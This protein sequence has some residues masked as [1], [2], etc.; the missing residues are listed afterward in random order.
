MAD[1]EIEL[2]KTSQL[3]RERSPSLPGIN[4]LNPESQRSSDP[5]LERN[6]DLEKDVPQDGADDGDPIYHYLTFQT[7]LPS[8]TT[9]YPT[10]AGQEQPPS[11]PDLV[12]FTSPFEWSDSRKN[13]IIWISCLITSL[14]AFTAG[15]YSP[16][17]GQ[18]TAEW[19]VSN[20][21]ALVGITT[22]TSGM[23][24]SLPRCTEWSNMT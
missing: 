19:H 18:M 17:I 24:H 9:I 13:Y 23:H 20:V 1:P 10:S 8:P 5:T 4:Q 15:A 3:G 2:P 21:A 14:T 7:E 11:P 6:E 22:F 16:G 12:K